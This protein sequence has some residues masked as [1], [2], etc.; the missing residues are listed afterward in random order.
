M[1]HDLPS[2]FQLHVDDWGALIY[3]ALIGDKVIPDSCSTMK[4]TVLNYEGGQGYEALWGVIKGTH[5]TQGRAHNANI[6]IRDAPIQEEGEAIEQYVFRYHDFLRLR[7]F[8]TNQPGSLNDMH[9]ITNLIQGCINRYELI[10]KTDVERDSRD[11]EFQSKYKDGTILGTLQAFE[12]EIALE[13]Q[14]KLERTRGQRSIPPSISKRSFKTPSRLTSRRS[15]D[16]R[17]RS[18]D[19]TASTGTSSITTH[20]INLIESVGLPDESATDDP[21]LMQNYRNAINAISANPSEFD[22]SRECLI[23]GKT[24]HTFANCDHL[25]DLPSLQRHRIAI[26][27]SIRK[28]QRIFQEDEERLKQ[29][30]REAKISQVDFQEQH[31]EFEY[32]QDFEEI[33]EPDEEQGQDFQ[34]GRE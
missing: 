16:I 21:I 31:D 32:E 30:R 3:S 5:P 34:S 9:E 13:K 12:K 14:S 15:S 1:P 24:G 27:Q 20:S 18:S 29:K 10:Q 11:E 7:V 23:C 22:T 19:R 6:L 8:L 25:N 4:A 33:Q 17:S 28:H 2:Q 26:G